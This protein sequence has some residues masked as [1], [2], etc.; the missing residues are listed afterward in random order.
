VLQ[1]GELLVAV[2]VPPPDPG[3]GSMYLRFIPRNE[4]DIAVVGAAAAVWLSDDGQLFQS[5]RVSLGAVA[6]IPLLVPAA[7][8]FLA[9]REVLPE[10]I[11]Q[12]AL[13]ARDAA[14]PIT[15]M[16][17]TA[18]QR[19]HLTGVITRRAIEGAIERAKAG[20]RIVA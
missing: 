6:P 15:D 20:L 2:H 1:P 18:D 12:A 9:G 8:D 7:G 19:R 3:F 16:R 11:R 5:A 10:N 4:M 14:R 17:G 13:L